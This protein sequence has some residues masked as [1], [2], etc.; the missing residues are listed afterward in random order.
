MKLGQLL[1]N[2]YSRGQIGKVY[3]QVYKNEKKRIILAQKEL[4]RRNDQ[5]QNTSK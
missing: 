4:K 5:R 2:K 3:D 1:V